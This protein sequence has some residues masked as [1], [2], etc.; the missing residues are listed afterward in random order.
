MSSESGE[1]NPSL[2]LKYLEKRKNPLT[3]AS[4]C[5]IMPSMT[6][7]QEPVAEILSIRELSGGARQL[8][9]FGEFL[10]LVAD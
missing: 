3:G 2:P 6:L 8:L 9:G 4:F 7:E 10:L 5:G 1:T